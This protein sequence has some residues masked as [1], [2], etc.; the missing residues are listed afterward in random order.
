MVGSYVDR[1][2]EGTLDAFKSE[3]T[4]MFKKMEI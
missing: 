1:Y 2:F 4:E 3:H